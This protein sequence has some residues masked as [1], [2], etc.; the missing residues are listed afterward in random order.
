MVYT[1]KVMANMITT[2]N[3]AAKITFV[4]VTPRDESRTLALAV[5][6]TVVLEV[7]GGAC[8][9]ELAGLFLLKKGASSKGLPDGDGASVVDVGE[10]AVEPIGDG[11]GA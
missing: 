3:L 7:T 5:V 4:V 8:P 9:G 6:G 11:E 10:T 2:A 1:N